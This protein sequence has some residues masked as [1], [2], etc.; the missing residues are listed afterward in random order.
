M[1]AH[2]EVMGCPGEQSQ[3]RGRSPVTFAI[4]KAEGRDF[5]RW[6][7]LTPELGLLVP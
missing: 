7:P 5:S 3:A 2:R 1:R 6:L 4:C